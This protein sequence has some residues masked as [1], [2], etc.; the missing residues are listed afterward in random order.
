MFD[1]KLNGSV[2]IYQKTTKDLIAYTLVDPFTN[3]GNRIDANIGDMENKG[4]ELTFNVPLMQTD[5]YE[6]II[7]FNIAFNDN[8][9]TRLPDLS[10]IHI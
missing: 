4:I 3:F 10:L 2:N 8:V 1:S 7:D 5:D 6:N 9:V